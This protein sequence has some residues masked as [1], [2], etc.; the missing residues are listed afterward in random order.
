MRKKLLSP[1]VAFIAVVV[2]AALGS[3][4][5]EELMLDTKPN[6][7]NPHTGRT[8]SLTASMPGDDPTT[9]VALVQEADNSITLT[10]E[11]GDKLQLAFVQGDTKVKQTVTLASDDI[12][13]EG[14]RATFLIIIPDEIAEETSFDLYGVYGG[15]KRMLSIDIGLPGNNEQGDVGIGSFYS[16]DALVLG[17]AG[18]NP[19]IKLPSNAG[20]ATSLTDVQRRKDVMLY[21]ESMA[22]DLNN[23]DISVMFQHL[24]SLFSITLKNNAATSLDN[25]KE[26][27]LVGIN[28]SD[29]QNWAYNGATGGQTY[30]LITKEFN[31]TATV[32]NHFS[33]RAAQNSVPA[34]GTITFWGWYPPMPGNSWPEL[35]LQL[36]DA[37]KNTIAT[38]SN[39]KPA[40]TSEVD[41]GKAYYFYAVWDEAWDGPELTFT[42]NTFG[43]Y[44]VHVAE[45]G[46][47][48]SL[49]TDTEKTSIRK[50]TVTGQINEADFAVMYIGMPSLKYLDLSQ[51]TCKDNQIPSFAFAG[52]GLR[53]IILPESITTIGESAFSH[54]GGLVGDLTIPANVTTIGENAFSECRGFTG[55]LTLPDTLITIGKKAFYNCFGFTGDLVIPASVTTIGENA[56]TACHGFTGS[57]TLPNG[58]STIGEGVFS[59][60]YGF[61]GSLKLPDRLET[62]GNYAFEGCDS[63]SGTVAFPTTLT[64]IGVEGFNGCAS[65]YGFEFLSTTPIDYTN[66]MLHSGIPVTVPSETAVSE[67]KT[68]WGE[69]ANRHDI[70]AT[71]E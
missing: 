19:Y 68:M 55:S 35:E 34:D 46:T 23:P 5:N 24:G 29:N 42:D 57:L 51:V 13:H 38:S 36:I 17:D 31:T 43:E 12:T 53:S 47:L 27:Q 20:S 41:A 33:F 58:L 70:T 30:D 1:I 56:F 22:V 65:I 25:L 54:C 14:K 49:F 28:N 6:D 52:K 37:T 64:S 7:A 2:L 67:Y 50:L 44:A 39:F 16:G 61:T 59:S 45:M 26:V 63:F 8:L 3:C 48:G 18:T 10:W 69:N 40:R 4:S 71:L 60:C 11:V 62:I 9:R 32:S 21:F 15:G 66:D